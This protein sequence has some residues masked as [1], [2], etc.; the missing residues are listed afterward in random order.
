MAVMEVR[1]PSSLKIKFNYGSDTNGKAIIKSKTYS[2][3][4]ADALAEDL[5][6]VAKSLSGL[7]QHDLYDIARID[8][9][10]LSE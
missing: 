4:K 2:Y 1:E 3:V 9:T 7:C 6:A 8:V 10:T 5:F